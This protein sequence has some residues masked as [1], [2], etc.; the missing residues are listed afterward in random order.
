M[1]FNC[2]NCGEAGHFARS[3]PARLPGT[4]DAGQLIAGS[5]A[6]HLDR[7]DGH[8]WDWITG[9]T[10]IEEKRRLISAENVG[11][12]GAGCPRRLMYP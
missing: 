12:Y 9:K 2:H 7:I 11:F 5:H 3:C 1:N 10:S 6:E 4:I 8:V